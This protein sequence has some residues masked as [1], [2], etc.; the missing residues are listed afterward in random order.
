MKNIPIPKYAPD[1]WL[2]Y[3]FHVEN[4]EEFTRE[5]RLCTNLQPCEQINTPVQTT[6]SNINYF[7]SDYKHNYNQPYFCKVRDGYIYVYGHYKSIFVIMVE[8]KENVP[9]EN[10]EKILLQRFVTLFQRM[11]NRD[12]TDLHDIHVHNL[13]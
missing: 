3:N 10:T 1:V 9:T 12:T 5:Q 2:M 8:K 7:V 13:P 11:Y 4:I 6:V